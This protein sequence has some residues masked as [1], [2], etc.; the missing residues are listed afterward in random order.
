MNIPWDAE[1][2]AR[3]FSFVPQYGSALLDWI[4]GENLSVLDLGCG[5]GALTKAL[6]ERGHEAE[7]IDASGELLR[8]A[9]ARY[10]ELRFTQADAVSFRMG[11]RYDVV[12]SNAVF[13][14]I[15]RERQ[16]DMIGQ[17]YD[18]LKPQGQFIV[19][20]VEKNPKDFFSEAL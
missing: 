9:R 5:S 14:W 15:D 16:A 7:G 19:S 11:K 2:Y 4:E 13:H 18:A 17:V 10:P 1:R 3:D 8:M 12:F 6:A 20:T